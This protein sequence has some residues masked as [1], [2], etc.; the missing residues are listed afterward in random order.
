MRSTVESRAAR[1]IA[2]ACRR[3][4]PLLAD[5]SDSF[6]PG[7]A[8][9][10]R[11]AGL[12]L[13]PVPAD[14][15]GLGGNL[16]EAVEA[17]AAIGA[18]DGA[19]ALGL[20]MHYQVVGGAVEGGGWP[21]APFDRLL[22]AVVRD[23]ALVNAASTEEGS[24]SPSRGGL[25]DTRAV[26]PGDAYRLTGEKT[27]TT[28][29]PALRFAVVSARIVD[30]AGLT[31]GLAAGRRARGG[32]VPRRSRGAGRRAAARIRRARHAGIGVRAASTDATSPS[33]RTC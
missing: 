14:R 6:Q 21:A 8:D 30:G 27:W 32:P 10:I 18:V 22:S 4:S 25:P 29:L 28:W 20:A 33:R 17:L 13:L 1:R 23:G 19:T 7:A 5:E 26:R 9:A 31:V 24:G 15:G 16:T 12:H 2:D 3:L 11:T